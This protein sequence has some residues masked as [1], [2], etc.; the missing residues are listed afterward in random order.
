LTERISSDF[1]GGGSRRF[2]VELF[3]VHPSIDP[4]EITAE[5]KM[6]GRRVQRAGDPRLTPKKSPLPGNY[7]DTRWRHSIRHDVTDQWFAQEIDKFVDTLVPHKRFFQKIRASGGEACVIIQ[8]FG[9]YFGDEVSRE[10]LAKMVDL[11]LDFSIE[12]FA[13]SQK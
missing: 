1:D 8:F 4:S 11:E 12:S 3:V 10:T 5:L 6:E 9:D 13:I 7:R 2:D